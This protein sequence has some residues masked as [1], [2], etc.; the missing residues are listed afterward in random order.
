MPRNKGRTVATIDL[1]IQRL[2]SEREEAMALEISGVVSR[3][4]EA[5]A[6]YGLTAADLG[7]D[8]GSPRGAGGKP[9]KT[10]RAKSSSSG[11]RR[12]TPKYT[13]GKGHTWTGVGKRP[14][15]YLDALAAGSSPDDLRMTPSSS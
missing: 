6:H 14:R 5:I 8:G 11:G 13:D 7:L 2:Q 10:V 15:W 4:K 9:Q 3:M 12:S 1:E